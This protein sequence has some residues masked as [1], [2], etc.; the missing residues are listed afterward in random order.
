M[1]DCS[2]PTTRQ[3]KIRLLTI[4]KLKM[5]GQNWGLYLL[6]APAVILLIL[7]AYK[8]MYGVLIAFKDYKNS[9]GIMG[10]PWA[11]PWYK[12][13]QQFFKSYQFKKTISNSLTISVYS[14]IAGFPLPIIMALVINQMRAKRFKKLFQTIT[15]L[16]H[17]IS[18]VVMV[19]L[20]NIW[21]SPSTG[22]IGNIYRLFGSEAPNLMGNAKAFSSIYVWSDVWQHTG[23]NSIIYI[24]ALAG[25]DPS[26]YEAAVVDGA[27]RWQ[28]LM[29]ID[30]PMLLPTASILLIMSVGNIMNVGFEKAY[31]MQNNINL[32]A[33]EIISTYVYKIGIL[34]SQLSYSAAINLFNT[35]INLI[36]LITVNQVTRKLSDNSLW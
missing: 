22:L 24:A 31:L 32:P 8:P 16:P 35:V 13:F 30:F 5:I 4:Q 15:Y 2:A 6:M 14:L 11:N 36:L 7:F 28:K 23:W 26:L 1:N 9:L 21:L 20:I 3:Q 25:I 12:Y 34:S 17:F 10:S 29:Y 19:G 27:S 33:S 18:I